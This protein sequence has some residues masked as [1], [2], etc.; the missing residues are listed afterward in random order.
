VGIAEMPVPAA[1]ATVDSGCRDDLVRVNGEPF[2]VEIRGA[3]ADARRGLDLVACDSS[4]A[5]PQGS[6]TLASSP[7]LTTGWDVDRVVLSSDTAG[8]AVPVTAAGA[9]K[10]DSG[11]T[12][13]VESSNEDS[14]HL[15]VRTDGKPFWLVLGQSHSDGWEATAAGR[16]LG[17]PT[18]VN[19]FANGWQVRPG[20]AGTIDITLRWTPQRLV[21]IG[22][23]ISVLAIVACLVLLF[24]RRR[25]PVTV[26]GPALCDE[27]RW[28]SPTAFP[29]E[30]PSWT[31]AATAAVGAGVATWLF[32]YWWIGLVVALA[33]FA[34]SRL[35]GGR[36]LV[37]AGAPVALALGA[38]LDIPELG[39]VA[40][41]LLLADLVAGWWFGR[42]RE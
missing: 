42:S 11:A 15:K 31:V 8:R 7:G 29:G 40:L 34:A 5:L 21:W 10:R 20:R 26:H 24:V 33:T 22:L 1:P 41:G 30:A 13:R 39:W 18:L 17:S 9:P 27:P 37:A 25:R 16:D 14:Y 2:P 6:N 28:S 4:L 36:L 38:L 3:R 19:G 32:S 35:T 23:G 12:V